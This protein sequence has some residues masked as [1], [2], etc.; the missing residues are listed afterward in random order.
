MADVVFPGQI[1]GGVIGQQ[2]L[3]SNYDLVIYRGDYFPL[4]LTL[5]TTGGAALNL[6][7]YTAKAQIRAGYTKN[8]D[9]YNFTVTFTGTPG[10]VSLVLPSSISTLMAPGS[11]IWDF[12][13]TDPAGNVRTYLAGDVT[14][15][16][17]VTL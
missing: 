10:E 3:P 14:V 6:T 13:L 4:T 2:L 1:P 7:G 17:E 11:Y 5:K 12:Q 16:D 9:A 8:S 15:Y